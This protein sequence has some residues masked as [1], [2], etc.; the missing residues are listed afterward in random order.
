MQ[1]ALVSCSGWGH[2]GSHSPLVP[3]TLCRGCSIPWFRT[4]E[5]SHT[6]QLC[7]CWREPPHQSAFPKELFPPPNSWSV[8]NP[9]PWIPPQGG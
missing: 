6:S 5:R 9:P 2:W 8:N 7:R 1:V 4:G 3:N